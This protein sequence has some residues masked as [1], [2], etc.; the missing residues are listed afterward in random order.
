VGQVTVVGIAT[1]YKLD[2]SGD[3]IPAE[4][5]PTAPVQTSPRAH[6]P[7][8]TMGTWSFQGVNQLV[9][10]INHPPPSSAIVR[11]SRAIHYSRPL[12]DFMAGYKMN[13]NFFPPQNIIP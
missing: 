1:H 7:S 6:P 12:C 9:H 2:G 4:V 11:E 8:Y 13:F 3:Q 10:G 5:R